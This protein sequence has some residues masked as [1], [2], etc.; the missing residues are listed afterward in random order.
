ML[1]KEG[2]LKLKAVCKIVLQVV[3]ATRHLHG[4]SVVHSNIR[5]ENVLLTS[6]HPLSVAL[7]GFTAAWSLPRNDTSGQ[8][9]MLPGTFDGARSLWLAPEMLHATSTG[10]RTVS[11]Q[12]DVF[13]IGGL[14]FEVGVSCRT[15]ISSSAPRG[16]SESEEGGPGRQADSGGDS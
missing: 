2:P 5:A 10:S 13:M 4:L 14:M 1:Q 3:A 9:Q 7:A 6:R 12:T 16:G 8:A 11:F 15:S